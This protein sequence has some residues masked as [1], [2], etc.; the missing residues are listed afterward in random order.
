V[1]GALLSRLIR[2]NELGEFCAPSLGRH[3][4][5]IPRTAERRSVAKIEIVEIIDASGLEYRGGE[6]VDPLRYLGSSI[7]QDL[8]AEQ[9]PSSPVSRQVDAKRHRARV[10]GFMVI[11]FQTYGYRVAPCLACVSFA[12]ASARDRQVE[13]L[14][15]LRS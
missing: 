14:Q 12:D 2:T 15:T 7:A 11:G 9:P 13:H 3:L 5:R 8:A 4:D 10:I 1:K 6:D